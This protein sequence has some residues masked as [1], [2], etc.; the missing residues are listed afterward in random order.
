MLPILYYGNKSAHWPHD[1]YPVF[2]WNILDSSTYTTVFQLFGES[3]VTFNCS[4]LRLNIHQGN[5]DTSP[6]KD[7]TRL[8]YFDFEPIFGIDFETN[9]L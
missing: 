9:L 8:I 2:V 6:V 4:N 3:I 5:L 1:H 7:N